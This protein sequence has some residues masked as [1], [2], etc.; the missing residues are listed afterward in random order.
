VTVEF[1]GP[2]AARASAIDTL[3]A[4]SGAGC[5]HALVLCPREDTSDSQILRLIEQAHETSGDTH[6]VIH[7]SLSG[8]PPALDRRWSTL[9]EQAVTLH[10]DI[11]L[12]LRLPAPAGLR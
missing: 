10:A 4:A 9:L 1:V 7:P 8:D 11:R 5:A 12:A 2:D 3:A 6:V